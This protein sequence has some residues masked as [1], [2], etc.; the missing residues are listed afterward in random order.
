MKEEKEK[1]IID[2]PKATLQ[3]T[4]GRI[5]C[6]GVSQED[7]K[8]KAGI[9]IPVEFTKIKGEERQEWNFKRYFVC[10][11]AHDITLK[12]Q[13]TEKNEL[14]TVQRGDEVSIFYHEDALRYSPAEVMDFGAK[15]KFIAF[16]ETEIAG[17]MPSLILNLL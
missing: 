5:Y 2:L 7:V 1:I 13:D 14:R 15:T 8:T 17:V 3:P 10:A 6:V 9:I 11:V 12:V 4:N 16:H